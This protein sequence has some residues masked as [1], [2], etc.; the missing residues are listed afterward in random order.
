MTT[1]SLHRA[2]P[3][4]SMHA[5][6]SCSTPSRAFP[7]CCDFFPAGDCWAAGVRT[8]LSKLQIPEV[9]VF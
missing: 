3:F 5:A 8:D 6:S 7:E 1:F 4:K 9:T 2:L